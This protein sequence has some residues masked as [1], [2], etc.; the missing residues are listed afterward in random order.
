MKREK[1]SM[2]E[3]AKPGTPG[4]R[5]TRWLNDEAVARAQIKSRDI[6]HQ[7]KFMSPMRRFAAARAL[8]AK[9]RSQ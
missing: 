3:N 2:F 9:G 4:R 6:K 5:M 7:M 8:A 1:S